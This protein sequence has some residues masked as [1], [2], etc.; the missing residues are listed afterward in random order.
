MSRKCSVATSHWHFLFHF[1]TYTCE[2]FANKNQF[3]PNHLLK[4]L[5]ETIYPFPIVYFWQLCQRSIDHICMGL[6]LSYLFCYISLHVVFMPM[7]MLFFFPY[8]W[9]EE[10]PGPGIESMPQQWQYQMFNP[11]SDQGTPYPC[12][13]DYCSFVIYFEIWWCYTSN[14]GI[15]SQDHLGY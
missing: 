3:F 14:F 10:A 11:P 5:I 12:C 13:F 8:L 7:L 1:G 4:L 2:R 6:F 15:F 9:H